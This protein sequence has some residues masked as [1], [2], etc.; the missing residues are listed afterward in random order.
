MPNIPAIGPGPLY[1]ATNDSRTFIVANE[2]RML[3]ELLGK[4]LRHTGTRWDDEWR[5]L[6][7]GLASILSTNSYIEPSLFG[8]DSPDAQ[9]LDEIFDNIQQIGYSVDWDV[10]GQMGIKIQ[11]HCQDQVA[12]ARVCEAIDE[13]S[14]AKLDEAKSRLAELEELE[15]TGLAQPSTA[16]SLP[17]RADCLQSIDLLERV[18]IE[19]SVNP[20]ATV[21]V[22]LMSILDYS[23]DDLLHQ[24]IPPTKE[25][26]QV[27]AETTTK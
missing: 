1:V 5:K 8:S 6:D 2:E 21:M 22:E 9:A 26:A 7:T 23:L 18:R 15:D 24:I 27:S 14:V 4:D 25:V 19:S 10:T 12:A 11:L 16:K 13:F 20:N 17:T 3:L